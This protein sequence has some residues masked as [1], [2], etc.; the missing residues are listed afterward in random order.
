MIQSVKAL[1]SKSDVSINRGYYENREI[2]TKRG[3]KF[4]MRDNSHKKCK[5]CNNICERLWSVRTFFEKTLH[6]IGYGIFKNLTCIN[7]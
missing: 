1:L 3:N 2:S 7:M 4:E 6:S 5:Q